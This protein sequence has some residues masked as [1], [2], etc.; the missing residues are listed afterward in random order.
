[1]GDAAAQEDDAAAWGFPLAAL[2]DTALLALVAALRPHAAGVACCVCRA[3]CAALSAPHLWRVLDCSTPPAPPPHGV[4]E[5]PRSL[6]AAARAA[7][8]HAPP[9]PM[10]AGALRAAAAK[11]RGTLECVTVGALAHWRALPALA[12]DNAATL[13]RVLLPDDPRDA[14]PWGP[15]LEARHDFAADVA[16]LAAALAA[17][18]RLTRVEVPGLFAADG[19]ADEGSAAAADDDADDDDDDDEDGPSPWAALR[20]LL[21]AHAAVRCVD[22]HV[23]G[24]RDGLAE[25]R[26]RDAPPLPLPQLS[27]AWVR[28]LAAHAPEARRLCLTYE[29]CAAALAPLTGGGG[30]GAGVGGALRVLELQAARVPDED[31]LAALAEALRQRCAVRAVRVHVGVNGAAGAAEA[32]ACGALRARAARAP[33]QL[34]W[35]GACGAPPAC[36]AALAAAARARGGACVLGE[37]AAPAL[38]ALQTAGGGGV[39][40]L[41][42]R[43]PD[44]DARAAVAGHLPPCVRDLHLCDANCE[45]LRAPPPSSSS[46]WNA[47]SGARMLAALP[48]RAPRLDALS[49]CVTHLGAARTDALAAALRTLRPLR[50]LSLRALRGTDV[51]ALAAPLA[52]HAA[53]TSLRIDFV[54]DDGVV[55]LATALTCHASLR[56]LALTFKADAADVAAA[57]AAPFAALLAATAAGGG[58]GGGGGALRALRLRYFFGACRRYPWAP[59]AAESE[60]DDDD[61]PAADDGDVP[62][63][64]SRRRCTPRSPR[65][66]RRHAAPPRARCAWRASRRR[67]A[68]R[69]RRRRRAASGASSSHSAAAAATTTFS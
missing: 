48:G 58:G 9:P 21:G 68:R 62:R 1:M 50:T 55:A 66:R 36:A 18:P 10:R 25:A 46:A 52:A 61:D 2:P 41:F 47:P 29:L 27:E 54:R 57:G 16:A 11:A 69:Q 67:W 60:S 44:D 35:T 64:R 8:P 42:L 43:L 28:R 24:R 15:F 53:L 22:V 38:A 31:A 37:P 14:W 40:R 4:Y 63:A 65:S 23:Y 34:H 13:R 20:A 32:L 7:A 5:A 19:D 45:V 51:A 30:G 49:L 3:W 17:C 26:D 59:A 6:A 33:A 39:S 56:S 12:R